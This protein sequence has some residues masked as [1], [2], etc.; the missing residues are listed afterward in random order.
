MSATANTVIDDLNK[1]KSDVNKQMYQITLTREALMLIAQCVEDISR[2]AAG[3]PELS[4][5]LSTLLTDT[6]DSCEKRDE[7]E[8]SLFVVKKELFPELGR[9]SSYAY[10]GGNQKNFM[11]KNLIGNT[12]QIYR[13]IYHQVALSEHWDSVYSSETLPSGNIEK[14][15]IELIEKKE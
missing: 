11:R 8:K 14:I 2:F 13:E 15:R 5:T 3:Q 7:I 10:N 9:D 1:A 12:Y 4:N 6:D